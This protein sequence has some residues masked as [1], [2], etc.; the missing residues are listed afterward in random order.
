MNTNIAELKLF[1]MDPKLLSWYLYLQR[2]KKYK[3][4]IK[5]LHMH[6]ST[7]MMKRK[8]LLLLR[9]QVSNFSALLYEINIY[10]RFVLDQAT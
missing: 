1:K 2:P 4:T 10:V 3:Q 8:S 5:Q 6:S 7:Q 9:C